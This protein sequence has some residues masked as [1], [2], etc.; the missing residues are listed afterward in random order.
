[1]ELPIGN[2]EVLLFSQT[3]QVEGETFSVDKNWITAHLG[4]QLPLQ[5]ENSRQAAGLKNAY[6]RAL[7]E[8]EHKIIGAAKRSTLERLEGFAR[9]NC[10][11]LRGALASGDTGHD[12][13]V[14]QQDLVNRGYLAADEVTGT[15]DYGTEQA[16]MA[17]E[18]YNDLNQG[19]VRLDRP[20]TGSTQSAAMPFRQHI[21]IGSAEKITLPF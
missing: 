13:R 6:L 15:Y 5:Y 9:E 1:M 21:D 12:V 18:G 2:D 19:G 10:T 11:C 8:F 4:I 7:T 14:M 20:G 3:Q 16:V 17:L